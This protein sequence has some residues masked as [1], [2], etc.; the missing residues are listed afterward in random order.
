MTR[1]LLAEWTKLRTLPSSVWSLVA[2][3]ALMVGGGAA[4]V[5]VTDVPGCATDP[6]GCAVEDTAVLLLSGVHLAQI[7]AVA[8]GVALMCGEFQPRLLRTTLAMWPR[9]TGVFAAKTAVVGAAV[10][11]AAAVGV[12][13][14]VIAGRP[15]LEAHG[16]TPAV[17]YPRPDL[18]SAEL[19]RAAVGTALYV[20]LIAL[21]ALGIGAVL[22]HA[23]A[24]IG[25]TLTLLY[26][27][28]V[29]TLLV[30]MSVTALHRVQSVLPMSA[31]LAVQTTVAGTGTAPLSPWGG[32]AVLG[33]YAASF[34][35]LGAVLV[36]VRDA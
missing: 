33:A 8:V 14:A 18:R 12:G 6:R 35:L 1:A 25:A 7:A 9:R 23:G 27:P 26:G 34:L 11:A 13:L 10:L 22:R 4:V 31:G 36:A 20:T 24:A 30:P 15:L 21:L 29:V 16:L 28:Y 2:V 19:W 32:L 3:A 17:G 5:L